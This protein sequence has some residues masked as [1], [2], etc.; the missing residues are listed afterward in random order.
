MP[1]DGPGFDSRWERSIYRAS[2]SSQGT[3]N[4][5]PS[6]NDLAVEGC[7]TQTNKQ[8]LCAQEDSS[9]GDIPIFV[10]HIMKVVRCL[11]KK[12]PNHLQYLS[13]S[14]HEIRFANCKATR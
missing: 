14:E 1:R 4:G 7:K 2:R 12:C 8:T 10:S 6:L 3:V 13:H 5:V 9:C 11:I